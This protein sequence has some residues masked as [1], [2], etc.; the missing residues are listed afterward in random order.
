[1]KITDKT[2]TIPT[3]TLRVGDVFRV[4]FVMVVP[5]DIGSTD[6]TDRRP[7]C[8]ERTTP[9]CRAELE[10]EITKSCPT[11]KHDYRTRR[12]LS[13]CHALTGPRSPSVTAWLDQWWAE[14]EIIP[15]DA[16]PCLAWEGVVRG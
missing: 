11:C 15:E 6:D 3:G 9:I 10:A 13:M 5:A 1:M 14:H 4:E 8:V 16:P 12:G 7:E 2:I